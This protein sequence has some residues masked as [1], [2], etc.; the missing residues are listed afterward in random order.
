MRERSA[1]DK[2]IAE[3]KQLEQANAIAQIRSIM[4][5][6]GITP[7]EIGGGKMARKFSGKCLTHLLRPLWVG[8]GLSP[9]GCSR[10]GTDI[11]SESNKLMRSKKIVYALLLLAVGIVTGFFLTSLPGRVRSD[12]SRAPTECSVNGQMGGRGRRRQLV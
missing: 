3:A 4:N 1:L 5:E 2:Q 7:G 10:P 9:T 11:S 8:I 6:F 12:A